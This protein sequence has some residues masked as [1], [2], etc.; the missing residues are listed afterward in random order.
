M[1]KN[2]NDELQHTARQALVGLHPARQGQEPGGLPFRR[3]LS[4]ALRAPYLVFGTTLF[5]ILV[6][7]FLAIT[8]ANSYVSTGKF[9]FT[10]SGAEST[11]VDPSRA[12]ETS[13]ETIGTA[14]SA[15]CV[16]MTHEDVI[17]AFSVLRLKSRV[18]IQE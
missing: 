5:G 9:L 11:R 12:T 13:Q 18:M 1:T 7:T 8:T 17:E 14:A 3:L 4:A 15:G 16:R 10:A 2:I 6:G